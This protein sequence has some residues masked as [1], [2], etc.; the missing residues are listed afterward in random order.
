MVRFTVRRISA[1]QCENPDSARPQVSVPAMLAKQAA[2][3][4]ALVAA[5]HAALSFV[6]P[7]RT[8]AGAGASLRGTVRP[9]TSTVSGGP[10]GLGLPGSL[11]AVALA[12]AVAVRARK[13]TALRATRVEW[14]RKVKRISGDRAVF[15]VSIPKPLGLALEAFPDGRG[16]GIS[17]I[18]PESNADKLNRKVCITE[19]DNGMWVLEGDR[20]IGVNGTETVDSTVEDIAKRCA[21]GL[22]PLLPRLVGESEGDSV[23]LTLVRNTRNGPI[24]VVIMPDKKF[25]TVRRNARLSSAVEF[26]LGREIK[27]GCIDGWCGTCWHRERTTGWLFKPCSDMITSDWD[28][29]MPMVLFPKPEKAG[30]ATLLQPRGA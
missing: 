13:S 22:P 2:V 8:N 9:Q 18:T 1:E 29:V 17:T 25:A 30:D 4:A 10:Q 6:G 7:A 5:L 16:V 26:A 24:K 20:V 14:F 21:E 3:A 23:T 28:N 11:A 19:E 15:D 12:G 27:Y